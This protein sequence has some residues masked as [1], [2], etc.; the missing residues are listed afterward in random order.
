MQSV[1]KH[2]KFHL[3]CFERYAIQRIVQ[4]ESVQ[5][6]QRVFYSQYQSW[7]EFLK[8]CRKKVS[9]CKFVWEALVISNQKQFKLFKF[10]VRVCGIEEVW[11]AVEMRVWLEEGNQEKYRCWLLHYN[12]RVLT[13]RGPSI[14]LV[15]IWVRVIFLVFFFEQFVTSL[16]MQESTGGVILDATIFTEDR[17]LSIWAIKAILVWALK[18]EV[19]DVIFGRIASCLDHFN[20]NKNIN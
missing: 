6:N 20:S 11:Q 19:A 4:I 12:D 13:H 18:V 2:L 5:R 7:K 10:S 15:W 17:P 14:I 9:I 16:T 8:V 3:L 1:Y